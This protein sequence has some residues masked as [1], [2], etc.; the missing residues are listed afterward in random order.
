MPFREQDAED[1]A[2]APILDHLLG[3]EGQV[4]SQ[5]LER[6]GV[7]IGGE[8]GEVLEDRP[9]LLPQHRQEQVLLAGEVHVDRALGDPGAGRHVVQPRGG[10]AFEGELLQRG[11]E[12]EAR[13]LGLAPTTHARFPHAFAG[14]RAP[15]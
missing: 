7:G 14:H 13:P 1:V 10:E 9:G 12:D 8:C 4:G 2:V 5:D 11:L 15:Y 3:G 6:G